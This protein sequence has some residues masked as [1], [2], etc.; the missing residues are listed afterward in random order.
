MTNKSFNSNLVKIGWTTNEP[1][2]R[3]QQLYTTGVPTPFT[4]EFII[5]TQNGRNLE[6]RIHT[7]LSRYRENNSREFFKI[8]LENL[9]RILTNKLGLTLTHP[10]PEHI[11]ERTYYEQPPKRFERCSKKTLKHLHTMLGCLHIDIIPPEK[12][13]DT[14][15]DEMFEKFRYSP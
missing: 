6:T 10:E 4:I 12:E 9:R 3:A 7:Y 13:G 15:I 8:D 14:D 2:K 5:E 11:P 1:T